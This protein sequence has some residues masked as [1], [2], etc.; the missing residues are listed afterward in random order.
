ECA[1]GG[2]CALVGIEESVC[3]RHAGDEG[4]GL[5][6]HIGALIVRKPAWPLYGALQRGAVTQQWY[7]AVSAHDNVVDGPDL[8]GIEVPYRR[9]ATHAYRPF[10]YS[11][12]SA[13]R[14]STRS[15]ATRTSGAKDGGDEGCSGVWVTWSSTSTSASASQSWVSGGS[16]AARSITARN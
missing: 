10:R 13:C 11:S 3:Q 8:V 7:T 16:C 1:C 6:D 12:D 14:A 4:S 2:R 5:S 15:R 9:R